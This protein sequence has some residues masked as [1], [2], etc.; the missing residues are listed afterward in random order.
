MWRMWIFFIKKNSSVC[1]SILFSL[2]FLSSISSKLW[3]E[4]A[5][6][7]NK[8][9]QKNPLNEICTEN[10]ERDEGRQMERKKR[11]GCVNPL[12][13]GKSSWAH[14]NVLQCRQEIST[15]TINELGSESARHI[16]CASIPPAAFTEGLRVQ[17]GST[18]GVIVG[19]AKTLFRIAASKLN[20]DVL[21]FCF[22]VYVCSSGV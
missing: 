7:N 3:L 10:T 11:L 15:S 8:K 13:L 19:K 20:R 18:A 17:T 6:I 12:A 9:K 16:K 22:R 2:L 1:W 5:A 4:S 14:K 21:H